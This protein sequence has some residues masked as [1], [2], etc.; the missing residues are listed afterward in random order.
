MVEM[1][2]S[3]NYTS[4]PALAGLLI[5]GGIVLIIGVLSYILELDIL[6]YYVNGIRIRLLVLIFFI[7]VL[8]SGQLVYYDAKKID[9][10]YASPEQKTWRSMTWTPGSWGVL[11]FFLWIILF[12]VYLSKREEIYWQNITVGYST[13]KA[14]ER[15]INIQTLKQPP[16][17]VAKK[18]KYSDNVGICPSCET[19]YPIRALE[20]S[21][22][23]NRCGELL[24]DDE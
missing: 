7:I 11:V 23:C 15:D 8:M 19:P 2:Q 9:A 24:V 3:K 13:L 22:Y 18:K 4:N 16:Q 1:V 17:P 14:I 6:I 12:P 5:I 20:R 21:K 10:G